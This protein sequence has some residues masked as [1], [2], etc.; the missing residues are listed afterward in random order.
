MIFR[1]ELTQELESLNIWNDK[2]S[3]IMLKLILNEYSTH[4]SQSEILY[5]PILRYVNFESI[6][7]LQ[8]CHSIDLDWINTTNLLPTN[9][10]LNPLGH[11][12]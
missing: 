12:A 1:T 3:C 11:K 9:S 8:W 7:N 6:F 10:L 4:K 5:W 2:E